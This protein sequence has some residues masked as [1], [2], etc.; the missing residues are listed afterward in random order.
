[1]T[2]FVDWLESLDQRR[3]VLVEVD[4]LAEGS[5]GTL[6]LANRPFI[7]R[8]DDSPA[9]V[10]YDDVILG[11][12]SYGRD[13]GGQN[14]GSLANSVGSVSLAASPEVVEASFFEFAGQSVRVYLGDQR[15]ARNEFQLVTVLT[16]EALEPT[17]RSDYVLKFRTERLDLADPLTEQTFTVGPNVDAL[18]PVCFGQCHNVRPVQVDEAGRVWAVHDGP[19]E[20]ISAVRVNGAAVSATKDLT[21]GTITLSSKPSGTLTA[22]VVGAG[23]A[24]AKGIILEILSRLGN[25]E[26]DSASLDTLPVDAVGFYSRNPTSFRNA[27]DGIVKTFGGFWGFSRLNVFKVGL[28]DRPK[29]GSSVALTPDDILLDGVSFL[30]RVRPATE[31]NLNYRK[32]YTPQDANGYEEPFSNVRKTSPGIEEIYPDAELK[33]AEVLLA[34]K[35]GADTEAE[36]RRQFF[37]KPLR[38]FEVNAFALPFAFEVG[39][40]VR[41]IYP[42]F[43]MEKGVDAVVLAIT[44][45]PLEGVTELRV[46]ING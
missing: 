35:A 45:E 1:M 7:S 22:D 36:R 10:P 13:M 43:G 16:A 40:E 41:L 3:T 20:A 31:V 42:Y 9:S 14:S 24:T 30:R 4:Y 44:D 19:V 28:I 39:Q 8:P 17:G 27:L 15:W 34:E 6:R 29:G 21:T 23:G 5:S 18:K 46:L 25:T 37:E 2:A 33:E 11:G 32:N 12:L 38:V 26:I